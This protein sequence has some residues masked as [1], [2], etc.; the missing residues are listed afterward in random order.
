[1]EQNQNFCSNEQKCT[2]EHFSKIKNLNKS[3]ITL[4]MSEKNVLLTGALHND[5]QE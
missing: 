5:V 4:T 3:L 1:M 2:F